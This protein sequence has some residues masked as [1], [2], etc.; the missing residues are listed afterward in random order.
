MPGFRV[1]LLGGAPGVGNRA[2][3][4]IRNRWPRVAV[5]G[6]ASPSPGFENSAEESARIIDTVNTAAPHLLVVG[7]GA[8][9]QEV[10]LEQHASQIR[11]PVAIAAGA[12]IDF[13]AGVQTRAPRWVQRFRLEWLFRLA[14]DPRRLAGRYVRD[15][16]IFPR[17]VA[18]EWRRLRLKAVPHSRRDMQLF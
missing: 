3:E 4:R 1:F 16:I 18:S 11:A 17:L 10:W 8:P 12:T 9:K 13:L 2:A 14:S 5:V 6:V 7:L 15:A